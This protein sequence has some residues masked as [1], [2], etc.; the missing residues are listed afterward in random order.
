MCCFGDIVNFV[1]LVQKEE[2][3]PFLAK[4]K[5][6]VQMDDH[7]LPVDVSVTLRVLSHVLLRL[8]S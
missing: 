6:L 8:A 2:V 3:I 7:N 5:S 1:P 4:I